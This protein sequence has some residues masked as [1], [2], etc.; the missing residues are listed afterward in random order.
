MRK[1]TLQLVI[2]SGE[3]RWGT[4]EI[5]I[6]L[7][8]PGTDWG[9]VRS[10][11]HTSQRIKIGNAFKSHLGRVGA[12]SVSAQS[13][14][15]VASPMWEKTDSTAL[16]SSTEGHGQ[17]VILVKQLYFQSS[18]PHSGQ[19]NVGSVTCVTSEWRHE[20]PRCD[21]LVSLF[22]APEVVCSRWC[23]CKSLTN[24]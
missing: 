9:G 10:Q 4:G 20:K 2:L 1:I 13:S 11:R 24:H 19:W 15:S 18:G 6:W 3:G 17:T 22:S 7:I 21:S 23:T 8:P 16:R 14:T 12:H 5:Q